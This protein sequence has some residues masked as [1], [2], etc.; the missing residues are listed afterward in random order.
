[1]KRALIAL[2]AGVAVFG[3]VFAFAA[4]LN[5]TSD[6]LAAGDTSVD[7][8]SDAADTSYTTSWDRDS[9]HF[10]VDEVTVEAPEACAHMT[11]QVA[12][13]DDDGGTL[14]TADGTLD[15]D[16]EATLEIVEDVDA[17]DVV[18]IHVLI[19]G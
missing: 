13:L 18:H 1:M 7:A 4:A 8:C 17:V 19:T 15:A 12:L 14:A 2:L 10:G 6:T 11:V 3:S 9:G 5:V 16:A